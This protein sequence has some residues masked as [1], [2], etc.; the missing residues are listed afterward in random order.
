MHRSDG[1]KLK[2]ISPFVKI[3]P[4]VMTRRSDAQ[5]FSKELIDTETIDAYIKEKRSQGIE[6]TY[7]HLLIALYVRILAQ[8]PCLNRFVMNQQLYARNGIYVSMA[9]KRSLN[10]EGEETTVKF[11]F[12]GKE[13][14]FQVSDIVRRTI[15]ESIA[16]GTS[17]ATDRLAGGIMSLPNGLVKLLVW[18]LKWMDRHNMLPGG[19]VQASPFHTSLFFTYLKS[20]NLDYIYHHLYD[21]GTTGVFVALGKSK[22]VPMVEHGAV[23]VKNCCEIGYVLD[24]RI[25]DGLY[26]SN[27]LRLLQKYLKDLHLLEKELDVITEDVP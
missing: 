27:S 16:A 4:Y 1:R 13:N 20:I 19:I 12:T 3:I 11:A 26:F 7:L 24:E 18:T 17:N 15:A 2:S 25:C 10:D 9:V 5:I 6:L 14:I 22:K 23:V 21:F 8:R